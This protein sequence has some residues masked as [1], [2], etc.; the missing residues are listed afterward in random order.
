ME[1]LSSTAGNNTQDNP[2][3]SEGA[4]PA[5]NTRRNI[6]N[7][8]ARHNAERCCLQGSVTYTIGT[9]DDHSS[10]STNSDDGSFASAERQLRVLSSALQKMASF[11]QVVIQGE[12]KLLEHTLGRSRTSTTKELADQIGMKEELVEERTT[13][14][15]AVAEHIVP[16][17][18]VE[19]SGQ[20]LYRDFHKFIDSYN[21][22]LSQPTSPAHVMEALD[23]LTHL[24]RVI[25][26]VEMDLTLPTLVKCANAESDGADKA[27]AKF[28]QFLKSYNR[29]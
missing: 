1:P 27:Y 28:A 6:E 3:L 11:R 23:K 21:A 26:H 16:S 5:I 24:K 15:H 4:P 12:K 10:E 29:D 8:Q 13:L 17:Q 9:V 20:L 22:I 19:E 14:M 2:V 7:L 25:Q 18:H